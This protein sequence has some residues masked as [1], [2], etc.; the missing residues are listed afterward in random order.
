MNNIIPK[1]FRKQRSKIIWNL[2]VIDI[3]VFVLN[4]LISAGITL[5]FSNMFEKTIVWVIFVVLVLLFN[6]SLIWSYKNSC[7][8]YVLIYRMFLFVL[9][10]KRYQNKRLLPYKKIVSKNVIGV[11]DLFSKKKLTKYIAGLEI[12]G[13]D[14]TLFDSE[15]KINYLT[16]LKNIL[17]NSSKKLTIIKINLP[18]NLDDHINNYKENKTKANN[19]VIKQEIDKLILK[20]ENQAE[21]FEEDSG[22]RFYLFLEADSIVEAEN[23]IKQ[24]SYS[25]NTLPLTNKILDA[26]QMVN[27]INNIWFSNNEFGLNDSTINKFKDDLGLLLNFK[28]LKV[29]NNYLANN[30]MKYKIT[31]IDELPIET[32]FCWLNQL[33]STSDATCVIKLNNLSKSKIRDEFNKIITNNRVNFIV[34]KQKNHIQNKSTLYQIEKLN[35]LADDIATDIDSLKSCQIYFIHYD[36]NEKNLSKQIK[37]FEIALKEQKIKLNNLTFLQFESFCNLQIGSNT[38]LKL[39][40]IQLPMSAFSFGYMFLSTK[41]NDSKGMYLGINNSNNIVF[42]DTYKIDQTRQNHNMVIMGQSGSGK[43]TT[44]KKIANDDI[45]SNRN[46]FIIDPEGEYKCLADKYNGFYVNFGNGEKGRINPLQIIWNDTGITSRS[47]MIEDH[48]NF[49]ADWIR[50]L[51]DSKTIDEKTLIMFKRILK[52]FYVFKGFL[53]C[54]INQLKNN[55]YPT[56]SDLIVYMN[57]YK[58]NES[59][60]YQFEVLKTLIKDEFENRTLFD[61]HST[62]AINDIINVFDL[63]SL[64]QKANNNFKQAQMLLMLNFIQQAINKN[65]QL[66]KNDK[67]Q[68]RIIVDE[69]HLLIDKDNQNGLNFIFQMVKKIRKYNGSIIIIT[70][71]PNDFLGDES[72]VKKTTAIINNAQYSFIM[73][74]SPKDVD[75]I[76]RLYESVGGLTENEKNFIATANRGYGLLISNTYQRQIINVDVF[77]FER[78]IFNLNYEK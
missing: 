16:K 34:S 32:N 20:F 56:F 30:E 23:E 12:V 75:S 9:I 35:E 21:N 40:E 73:K 13:L 15:T 61:G 48:I 66:S 3:A 43:S 67:K 6:T 29:N 69:A 72:I 53:K 10:K 78:D 4:C 25:F 37:S 51:Y 7:R 50:T 28:D 11:K 68:I 5:L 36:S 58:V 57:T 22:I 39:N 74:L 71:N 18:V 46:V 76:N 42:L 65:N 19:K 52:D 14:I 1:P 41:L 44:V 8:Y 47:L 62:L 38:V 27:V 49:V 59:E 63:Y 55:D 31:C 24:L 17:L 33:I 77:D 70:Q 26:N 45:L 60:E 2:N 54:D 64:F